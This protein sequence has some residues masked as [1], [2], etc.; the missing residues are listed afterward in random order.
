MYKRQNECGGA[1]LSAVGEGTKYSIF[2]DNTSRIKKLANGSGE[3]NAWWHR[4]PD[5]N[6]TSFMK[7][8]CVNADGSFSSVAAN[9][10]L[11]VN[12]GFCI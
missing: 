4:S 5:I 8:T 3:S 6:D 2:T 9:S 11:G 1:N 10:K 12:F 7:Y